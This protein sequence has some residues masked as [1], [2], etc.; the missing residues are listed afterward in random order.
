MT[1]AARKATVLK[2]IAEQG[3]LTDSLRAQL[4]AC[5]DLQALETLY[6]PY[7][8]KRRTRATIARERGLQP[9][10]DLLLA[11]A[12]LGKRSRPP[13]PHLSIPTRRWPTIKPLYKE[14]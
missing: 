8:P 10:A 14:H 11:Q 9:L 3:L 5:S 12:A 6:L 1:L 13:C 2:T 7:K 4:E